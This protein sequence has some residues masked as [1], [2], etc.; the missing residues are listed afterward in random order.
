MV[1]LF[2]FVRISINL[3]FVYRTKEGSVASIVDADGL[4]VNSIRP[5]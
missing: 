3:M 4:P 5:S 1:N 2:T